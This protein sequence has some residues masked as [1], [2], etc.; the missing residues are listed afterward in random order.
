[1]KNLTRLVQSLHIGHKKAF[2]GWKLI[3]TDPENNT[4]IETI[5]EKT[6]KAL[7]KSG[8]PVEG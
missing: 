5:S 8:M 6:A 3:W 2:N 4:C 1:M 7:I